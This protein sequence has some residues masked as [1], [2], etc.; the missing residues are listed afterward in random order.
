MHRV[1]TS[2]GKKDVEDMGNKLLEKYHYAWNIQKTERSDIYRLEER[3]VESCVVYDDDAFV[4][5][6]D[7]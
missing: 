6:H 5:D 1:K 2:K 3:K 7:A 4:V